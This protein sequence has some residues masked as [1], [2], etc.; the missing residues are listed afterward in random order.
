MFFQTYVLPSLVCG[1]AGV[2][3]FG[4][5]IKF[6][7]DG[8]RYAEL[9]TGVAFSIA[10]LGMEIVLPVYL[11]IGGIDLGAYWTVAFIFWGGVLVALGM[12]FIFDDILYESEGANHH[13]NLPVAISSLALALTLEYLVDS[14]GVSS[15][16]TAAV[17]LATFALWML[18]LIN[19]VLMLLSRG[20]GQSDSKTRSI[21]SEAYLPGTEKSQPPKESKA[22]A[23]LGIAAALAGLISSLIDVLAKLGLWPLSHN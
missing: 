20:L 21:S 17:R 8:S 13:I 23:W 5:A 14:F 12:Y 6:L 1:G 18:S 10:G 3:M 7:L 9:K 4:I 19:F 22:V 15:G 16:F 2:I 11:K